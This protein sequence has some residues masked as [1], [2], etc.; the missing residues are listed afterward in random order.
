M[1]SG[2]EAGLH[3][4]VM[5]GRSPVV[6]LELHTG[7]ASGAS[8]LYAELC[9]WE[10]RHVDTGGGDYLSLA[11][12][13]GLG[14]GIVECATNRPVWLPYV[15]VEAI[16]AATRRAEALGARVL[17]EPREGPAGWRSV[18]ASPTG[19]ELAFWQAKR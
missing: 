19:G 13:S 10:P 14:G 9:G 18:I 7:N 1:S 17:L 15:E 11:L 6:H 2:L 4:R 12:G 16:A 3:V 8:A 5:S